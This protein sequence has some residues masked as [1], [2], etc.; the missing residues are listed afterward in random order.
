MLT[1][2][3]LRLRSV[4][5]MIS[6]TRINAKRYFSTPNFDFETKVNNATFRETA[7]IQKR[8]YKTMMATSLIIMIVTAS[9]TLYYYLNHDEPTATKS[10]DNHIEHQVRKI[11]EQASI[12]NG[13]PGTSIQIMKGE[14]IICSLGTGYANVELDA[15]AHA[16]TV[17]R[18][19]SI[20][21]PLTTAALGILLEKG[22]IALDEP[23]FTYLQSSDAHNVNLKKVT[24]R[25]LASHTSGFRNYKDNEFKSSQ[26][27]KNVTHALDM[28]LSDD[29]AHEPGQKYL[30][31][32][33]NYSLLSA[34]MEKCAGVDF[35]KYMKENVF[36]PLG[37]KNTV[38]DIYE[39]IVMER[40]QNYVRSSTGALRNAPYV[41]LSNKWA[42][43]GFL[44]T[45][46]D[47]C[48]FGRAM[49]KDKLLAPTTKA[50]LFQKQQADGK[51]INYGLGWVI[52]DETIKDQ[53]IRMISH[54]GGA[55]GA[56]SLLVLIP[57]HDI[58]LCCLV[59]IGPD[60][61]LHP[62]VTSIIEL[63]I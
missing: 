13:N 28:F 40:S 12:V 35:L 31:S 60:A 62:T 11:L 6:L 44:S 25:Q 2:R 45:C 19:A 41:N 54:S 9:G 1:R 21:K 8:I 5:R 52:S 36:K 37:M 63:I 43:G 46:H 55:I 20:S 38:P 47:L 15:K 34:V 33:Y 32:T 56:S 58:V 51:D 50:L 57:S 39:N 61:N 26:Q 14:Q 48:L 42:G 22:L 3:L 49:M 16:G 18:I 17:Y 30:Y 29:L 23:A 7:H 27:F 53:Q 59:N 10:T 24:I 4:T